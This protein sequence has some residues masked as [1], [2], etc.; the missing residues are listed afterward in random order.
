MKKINSIILLVII[1][2]LI[3]FAEDKNKV[4]NFTLKDYD[5]KK[6]S[7]SEFQDSSAVVVMFIATRCPVSNDYNER[8]ADLNKT[9][10]KK[11]IAF[12]GINSNKKED[13]DEVKTHAEENKLKFIILKDPNN[14][15]ADRFDAKFTPE[16]FVLSSDMEI[17]Y[18]GRIDDSRKLDNVERSDLANTLDEILAG[19]EVS[20]PET[21]AFG[22]SIKRVEK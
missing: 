9:Y 16:I 20:N 21:K 11:G 8:M 10:S 4:E 22:C 15:I 2:S 14:I 1:S 7:L 6:Y 18:H 5:G 19:K 13:A 17:V 3:L 12:I